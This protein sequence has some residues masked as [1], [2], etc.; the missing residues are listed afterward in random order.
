MH[1]LVYGPG[2]LG[3]TVIAAA[4]AAGWPM[5]E[6]MA[7]RSTAVA[8]P[9]PVVDVVVDTSRGDA[10]L[11][12]LEHA[13]RAGNRSFVL[14]AT[15]W[16]ADI[17]AVRARLLDAGAAAVV[18]PNLSLGA[19]LFLRLAEAAAG[20]YAAAGG[21]EPSI[22]E[23][24]RR[25]KADRPSGTA[26]A[27][28]RRILPSTRAGPPAP[29]ARTTPPAARGRRDPRRR[30]PGHAP[31]DLRRRGEI[32]RAPDHRPRP[33]R[34]CRRRPRRRPMARARRRRPPAST[35][36]T[37]SSTTCSSRRASPSPPDGHHRHRRQPEESTWPASP[38]PP[39]PARPPPR[40]LHRP[41]HPVHRRRRPRRGRVPPPRRVAGP[42]RHRRPRPGRHDR[43]VADADAG[44]ARPP[45]RAHRPDRRRAA[46][47]GSRIPVI[48]GT[49]SNDTRASIEATRRAAA[50]GADAALVVTPYYNRPDQ[51]ML[52]AH[53]RAVADEGGLPIVVYNVPGR[54]GANVEADTIL[55]LA[56]HPR[57]VAVKE[58]SGNIEQMAVI[59]RDRPRD[60]AVLSGD[61]AATL[62][63]LALGGD[64][65]V[66]VASNEIP[67]EMGALS[68]PGTPATPTARAGSTTAGCRC[69]GRTSRAPRT[70][71]PRRP[72][73]SR[74]A[75]STTTRP[76][77]R[78]CPSTRRRASGSRRSCAASGC[79][80]TAGARRR[81]P[82]RRA[83]AEGAAA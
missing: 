10:V 65:V 57:V 19:A 46:V 3:V 63:V 47:A 76:A 45:H 71:C 49:G 33:V 29:A 61:D 37:P 32:G 17:A 68:R 72:R 9:A 11:D 13:L 14:A 83:A 16:D 26:R 79:S 18:A 81:R 21:F 59:C 43:R 50:L 5:P 35:P 78:C 41:R 69:S 34:L 56:E 15:G 70:P 40:R 48:A 67:G 31:R 73:C 24:H 12:N 1:L 7:G 28:A 52:E 20:W 64:G 27:I 30:G 42:R 82:G 39:P 8:R 2:R 75:C 25:G 36:S 22:V 62:A 54:T 74:W 38:V 58:A 6:S 44:R 23:W 77:R 55:R 80:A 60:V 53:F 66:S 4:T 51:R